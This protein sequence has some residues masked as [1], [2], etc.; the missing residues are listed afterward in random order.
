MI[1]KHH[2][3]TGK[4]RPHTPT[5]S[6]YSCPTLRW[7]PLWKSLLCNQQDPA[8]P[9]LCPLP[10]RASFRGHWGWQSPLDK[11]RS[12][13]PVCSLTFPP[14]AKDGEGDSRGV[15][16]AGFFSSPLKMVLQ[17]FIKMPDN[18]YEWIQELMFNWYITKVFIAANVLG[19]T[20]FTVSK[21]VNVFTR[22]EEVLI[23]KE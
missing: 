21:W 9:P 11:H 6:V 5:Q 22:K 3:Q 4:H 18:R 2:K 15:G 8:F 7:W 19:R 20:W 23:Q 1:W 16:C 17:S 12:R 13:A 10:Q 14:L